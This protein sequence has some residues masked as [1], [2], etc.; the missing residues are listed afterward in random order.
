MKDEKLL[1]D[2]PINPVYKKNKNEIM[3]KFSNFCKVYHLINLKKKQKQKKGN[4]KL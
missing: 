4:Y 2:K 1:S 3:K